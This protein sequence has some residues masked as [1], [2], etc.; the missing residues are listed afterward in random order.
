MNLN[1][2]S[3]RSMI[4][5]KNQD[6]PQKD[7]AQTPNE[8][9]TNYIIFKFFTDF[10]YL[11]RLFRNDGFVSPFAITKQMAI[12]LWFFV[13]LL[14]FEVV[15]FCFQY[16]FE[17]DSDA[18]KFIFLVT[19]LVSLF[20]SIF[21]IFLMIIQ[22]KIAFTTQKHLENP[23]YLEI[24]MV[25]A[26]FV[27]S[28]CFI[29]GI[30]YLIC[31]NT[32]SFSILYFILFGFLLETLFFRLV[33]C[34][35]FCIL[36]FIYLQGQKEDFSEIFN[37]E[38]LNEISE[39][40]L[41]QTVL[42]QINPKSH[43]FPKGDENIQNDIDGQTH[44]PVCDEIEKGL[45]LRPKSENVQVLEEEEDIQN[46]HRHNNNKSIVHAK[47]IGKN[48]KIEDLGDKE[49]NENL[50]GNLV[51]LKRK[52]GSSENYLIRTGSFEG[53]TVNKSEDKAQP[54]NSRTEGYVNKENEEIINNESFSPSKPEILVKNNK[55]LFDDE[56]ENSANFGNF[57]SNPRK[58]KINEPD[59]NKF[60]GKQNENP[61][62][63]EINNNFQN[64]IK[65]EKEKEN[66]KLNEFNEEKSII[67]GSALEPNDTLILKI[68]RTFS[69]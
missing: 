1:N 59:A 47:K 60:K 7:I 6:N 30:F 40:E 61:L 21:N 28:I 9:F 37:R 38:K 12:F 62:T 53:S 46:A 32:L 16:K 31:G 64:E 56:N 36:Y 66:S 57:S 4:L 50:N 2:S 51:E 52:T 67:E 29:L 48:I 43:F 42:I 45:I 14:I 3:Q 24:F 8:T 35:V 39:N 41:K 23:I 17:S 34:L 27:H 11:L 55:K 18:F 25:L 58:N 10:H 54:K 44:R 49:N 68:S 22:K 13:Y 15:I 26:T 5:S 33:F 65:L 20:F 19:L 63:I 69:L